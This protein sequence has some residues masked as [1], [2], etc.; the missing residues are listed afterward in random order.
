MVGCHSIQRLKYWIQWFFS[1]F[2]KVEILDPMVGCHVCIDACIS[3]QSIG[4]HVFI[5]A[6]ICLWRGRRVQRERER[7]S[8]RARG[9][10]GNKSLSPS[11]GVARKHNLPSWS[12]HFAVRSLLCE[13]RALDLGIT[14]N[15]RIGAQGMVSCSRTSSG[16]MLEVVSW[17]LHRGTREAEE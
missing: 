13:V 8:E 6:S 16:P 12:C 7:A 10:G 4:C 17:C 11:K 2:N 5:H 9:D 14:A 15:I 3:H 1:Y